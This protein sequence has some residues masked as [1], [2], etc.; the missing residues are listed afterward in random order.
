MRSE[1]TLALAC[2]ALAAAYG[3]SGDDDGGSNL[4]D[5]YGDYS[6]ENVTAIGAGTSDGNVMDDGSGG[7]GSNDGDVSETPVLVGMPSGGGEVCFS[8]GLCEVPD[9][10][11][12]DWCERDGGPVDLIY[13]DGEVVETICYPPAE[14]PER[15]LVTIDSTQM[16]NVD[17]VQ[18]ANKTTVVFSDDTNGVPLV[19]D[20]SVDGNN[21]AIYG[22]GADNTIIDGNVTFD[23]NN[24]RLRG[25][26]ITGDLILRKNNVA[27]VL[28][29]IL[30]NVVLETPSTNGS[31]F[32][33]NDIFGSFSSDSNG[34]LLVGNDVLG[35]WT[36]TG[37]G[38]ICDRNHAFTDGNG[39][40]LVDDS[41]RGALLECP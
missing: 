28:C 18:M 27:I 36:I 10:E 14:D 7:A 12:T 40:E 11:A 24:A 15:P 5:G 16:G 8:D 39:D 17:V 33:E 35:E 37:N 6:D 13:V 38:T 30:G 3:C 32:A 1:L 26:T 25:L 34:N 19:G 2:L 41:E 29:K 22:N 20:V 23:G 21:V 4:P 9:T 31:V